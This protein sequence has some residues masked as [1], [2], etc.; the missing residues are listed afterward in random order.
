MNDIQDLKN[1]VGEILKQEISDYLPIIDEESSYQE[2]SVLERP[3]SFAPN[4]NDIRIYNT[5]S[6]TESRKVQDLE[7]EYN[8]Y[9]DS[10]YPNELSSSKSFDSSGSRNSSKCYRTA[11]ILSHQETV[12]FFKNNQQNNNRL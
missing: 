7:S 1:K 6:S 10:L 12:Q 8:D 9:N 5:Y 4:V 3:S 11:M 2:A